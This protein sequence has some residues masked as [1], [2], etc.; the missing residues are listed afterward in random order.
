M[1][2]D[3]AAV[4]QLVA[5][6]QTGDQSAFA[7]LYQLHFRRIYALCSRMLA[8]NPLGEEMTQETFIKAWRELPRFRGQARFSTWLH[9]IA[10]NTVLAHQRLRRPWLQRIT[11]DGG[12]PDQPAEEHPGT[13]RDLESAIRRLPHRARQVF[14]LVDVEG[15]AHD[16]AAEMLGMAVGT[17]KAHLSRA[18]TLLRGLLS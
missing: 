6:A 13:A 7:K 18:R 15:Y 10:V 9:R 12:L 3:E 5:Q 17:S 8:D 2:H 4:A 16:E 1:Q 14:V 11:G